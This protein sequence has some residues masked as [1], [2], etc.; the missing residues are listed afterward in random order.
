M[1]DGEC[2]VCKIRRLIS[3]AISEGS[4]DTDDLRGVGSDLL[5]LADYLDG[6]DEDNPN[7]TALAGKFS[8]LIAFTSLGEPREAHSGSPFR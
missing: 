3:E 1:C 5:C 6:G 7:A 2:V 8:N 4:L